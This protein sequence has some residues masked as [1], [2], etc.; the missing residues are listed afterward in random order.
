M[1]FFHLEMDYK[2]VLEPAIIQPVVQSVMMSYQC[3]NEHGIT[4][5]FTG[6]RHF[7]H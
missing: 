4:M 3:R 6:M 2:A 5:V 7:R 1:L